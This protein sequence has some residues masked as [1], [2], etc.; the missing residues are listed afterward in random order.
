MNRELFPTPLLAD[1]FEPPFMLPKKGCCREPMQCNNDAQF[2]DRYDAL[3][4]GISPRGLGAK[5]VVNWS[6]DKSLAPWTCYLIATGQ[7]KRS[8]SIAQPVGPLA[9][10][11]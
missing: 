2:A 1:F 9:F 7:D 6:S 3:E 10:V 4:L 5:R 8:T 11:E